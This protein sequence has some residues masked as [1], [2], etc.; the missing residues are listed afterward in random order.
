MLS[1]K[2]QELHVLRISTLLISSYEINYVLILSDLL[3]T[4][5]TDR[6]LYDYLNLNRCPDC[7]LYE[8]RLLPD[9]CGGV[10]VSSV[11]L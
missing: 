6:V 2:D 1:I 11:L 7:Q 8:L 9:L 3:K 5:K 4:D 10:R